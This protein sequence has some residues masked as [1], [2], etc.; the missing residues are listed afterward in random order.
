M[1]LN[2]LYAL[3]V[4]D[5]L[6]EQSKV[7]ALPQNNCWEFWQLWKFYQ[8]YFYKH[9]LNWMRGNSHDAEEAMSQA[10]LKAWK[11]WQKDTTTIQYPKAS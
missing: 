4:R 8:E 2:T 6:P 1:S 7:R 9:C 5:L 3:K 11:E 10:M